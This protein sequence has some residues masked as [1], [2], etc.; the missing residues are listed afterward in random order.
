MLFR[1]AGIALLMTGTWIPV[2][3]DEPSWE[4]KTIL[5][6][7]PGVKLEL[8]QAEKIAPKTAGIAKD[9]MFQV[10]TDKGGRLR[11]SSRRQQGSIARSDAVLFDQAVDYFTKKLAADPKDSHALTARGLALLSRNEG[12]KALVDLDRAIQLDTGRPDGGMRRDL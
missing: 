2:G 4:R 11:I 5:L 9:L 7:R 8:P 6:T 12:D 10:L 1:I 3:A